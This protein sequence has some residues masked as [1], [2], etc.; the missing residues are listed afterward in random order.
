MARTY[1]YQSTKNSIAR[2]STEA[3]IDAFNALVG[4][5]CWTSARASHDA[6]LIDAL[7]KGVDVSAICDGRVIS[8]QHQVVLSE[9]NKKLIFA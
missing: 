1:K 5:R 9:D 7:K 3:L 6:A 8:F 4:R 2:K